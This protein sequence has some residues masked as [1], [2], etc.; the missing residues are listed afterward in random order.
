MPNKSLKPMQEY[1]A[2]NL[3]ACAGELWYWQKHGQLPNR[4][5]GTYFYKAAEL[6]PWD[7]DA[8]KS[9]EREVTLQAIKYT[10]N[11]RSCFDR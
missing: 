1:V 9:V 8:I 7:D 6:L 3:A 2:N 5:E 4:G 11:V 10:A